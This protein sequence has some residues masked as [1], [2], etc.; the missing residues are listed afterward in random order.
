M[1]KYAIIN[2]NELPYVPPEV[3]SLNEGVERCVAPRV[4][5]MRLQKLGCDRQ[6]GIK[7]NVVNVPIDL[8]KLNLQLPCPRLDNQVKRKM[9]YDHDY[10]A[11]NIDVNKVK[12]ALSILVESELYKEAGV[13]IVTNN[14]DTLD[15]INEASLQES[16]KGMELSQESLSSNQGENLDFK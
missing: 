11:Q 10:L 2:G 15:E 8:E 12:Q 14:L 7:S 9:E 4:Q 1:P 13:E 6:R 3:K 16:M 5:F